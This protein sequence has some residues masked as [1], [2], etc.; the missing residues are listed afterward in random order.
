[1]TFFWDSGGNLSFGILHSG[2]MELFKISLALALMSC[3]FSGMLWDFPSS[4]LLVELLSSNKGAGGKSRVCNTIG[5][6]GSQC[7]LP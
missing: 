1:M 6:Y 5:E 3:H 7:Q 4:L 2:G